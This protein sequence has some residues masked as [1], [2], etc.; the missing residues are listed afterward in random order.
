MWG[1]CKWEGQPP[2]DCEVGLM[3]V[4]QNDYYG[5]CLAME[6]G[7]WEQCGGK[8]WPQ[9]GQCREGTCTFVNEYYS[10]CMP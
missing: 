5:Q 8:D 4:V 1:Q 7:L 10:Q 6:A 9:P 2:V 3:C